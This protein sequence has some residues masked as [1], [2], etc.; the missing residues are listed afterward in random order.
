MAPRKDPPGRSQ[1]PAVPGDVRVTAWEAGYGQGEQLAAQAGDYSGLLS[2]VTPRQAMILLLHVSWQRW[3]E[4]ATMLKA[5][6]DEAGGSRSGT[7]GVRGLIGHKTSAS[8]VTGGIYPTGEEMRALV[9]L[10]G[11]ERDRCA[12]LARQAHEMGLSGDDW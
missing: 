1:L 10:E 4:Y 11:Q 9:R 7:P 8:S 2:R 3:Q 12:A 5:Q 6:V